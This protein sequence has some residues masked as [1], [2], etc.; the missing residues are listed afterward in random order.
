VYSVDVGERRHRATTIVLPWRTLEIR[1]TGLRP[2]GQTRI[3]EA[4]APLATDGTTFVTRQ[5]SVE[6]AWHMSATSNRCVGIRALVG[7]DRTKPSRPQQDS[8]DCNLVADRVE[9]PSVEESRPSS[10]P[11]MLAVASSALATGPASATDLESVVVDIADR[12]VLQV[13]LAAEEA[14]TLVLGRVGARVAWAGSRRVSGPSIRVVRARLDDT[15]FEGELLAEIEGVIRLD[16]PAPITLRRRQDG[17][18]RVLTTTGFVLDR[19]WTG[20]AIRT[21]I[22]DDD[23]GSSAVE[24]LARPGIVPTATVRRI[25]R[26]TGRSLIEIGLQ[27]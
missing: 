17:S 15:G 16:R 3:T 13:R 11:R 25:Q 6:G 22:V 8:F 2:D 5:S 7:Y 4:P 23:L 20:A 9:Q 19:A 1:A 27:P 10:R 18:V 14:C 24:A 12:W 26:T 21:L